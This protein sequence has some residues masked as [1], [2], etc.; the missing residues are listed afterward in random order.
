MKDFFTQLRQRGVIKVGI[1]YLVIA[2]GLVQL[3]DVTFPLLQLP[4]W[5]I[6]LVLAL[7]IIGFPI[8]MVLAWAYEMT[9]EGPQREIAVSTVPEQPALPAEPSIID[10]NSLAVLPFSNLSV[11]EEQ[12]HFCDGLTE[13]LIR[14]FS[15]LP[16]IRVAS[17][18]SSFAFK[19]GSADVSEIADRLQVAYILEGSVRKSGA[20]IRIMAQ[21]TESASD[22][23]L[24]AE[25][26][27]RQLDDIFLIQDD[28]ASRI[29]SELKLQLAVEQVSDPTTSDSQA[30]DLF[31]RGAGY[32]RRKGSKDQKLAIQLFQKAVEIDPG[33]VRGWI[34]LAES[35]A[36]HAIFYQSRTDYSATAKE[37]G[38]KA[39]E[40][41]PEL[42][43]SYLS[44]GLAFLAAK[45][46]ASAETELKKAVELDPELAYAHH[47]LARS[48]YLQGQL[49]NAIQYFETSWNL[50]PED[51][52]SPLLVHDLY[53]KT[54]DREG[55]LR[56]AKIGVD[57]V[58]QH[59]ENYPD[60]HRAYYLGASALI[61][62]GD[63][64][65][66]RKW[67]DR[68][69]Q[70]APDDNATRYNLACFYIKYGDK[71]KA[72]DFLEDSIASREWMENDPSLEPLRKEPRFQAM[73]EKLAPEK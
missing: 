22:S 29:L 14:V 30:Y 58:E 15:A 4:E 53:D 67:A 69:Y 51:F 28:I 70:L 41:A 8:A 3:A 72:L 37:A 54:G 24:W 63:A 52:E 48:S 46:Y 47:W 73:L 40:L 17:R 71:D 23:T 26:Y 56:A 13:E 57:R 12:E 33:F 44:R 10:N 55:A 64:E 42:A 11:E 21:L 32:A 65:L 27:D 61:K 18:T 43:E 20:D 38:N 60:N 25:T 2:W 66:A 6:T 49:E 36:I 7:L 59:V 16:G 1:A 9:P 62:L 34:R 35:A 5:T 68:A 31:L 19:N 45:Q 39:I 50:D